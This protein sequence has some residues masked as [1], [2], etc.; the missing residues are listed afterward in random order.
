MIT[1]IKALFIDRGGQPAAGGGRHSVDEL[2]LAAA[3][4]LVEAA[5][6]D[7]QFDASERETIERLLSARFDLSEKEAEDL[8]AEAERAVAESAQ[9]LPFTRV[10]KDRFS[11]EER[12]GLIEML[13]E[14][15][16]ADG[17]L[18][19]FEAHLLRRIGGL[20]YVSDKER[21]AARKRVMA[22]LGIADEPSPV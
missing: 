18:H 19:D 12:V 3:A 16:Y 15:A 17:R 6:M 7:E 8:L 10:V 2:H 11:P 21:G 1:R 9:L 13:W 20:I 14:V 5:C 22:R 4:L